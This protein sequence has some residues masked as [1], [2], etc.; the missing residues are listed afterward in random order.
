[1]DEDLLLGCINWK[2]VLGIIPGPVQLSPWGR[3]ISWQPV[4]PGC[5][6]VV[7]G[8]ALGDLLAILWFTL[9]GFLEALAVMTAC[10]CGV[11]RQFIMYCQDMVGDGVLMHVCRFGGEGRG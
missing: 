3:D 2:P 4:E 10:G 7:S 9:R 8:E 1:M 5:D 6:R 11:G